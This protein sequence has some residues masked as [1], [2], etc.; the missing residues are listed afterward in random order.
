M[1]WLHKIRFGLHPYWYWPLM[2]LRAFRF[3]YAFMRALRQFLWYS[4]FSVF[5]NIYLQKKRSRKRDIRGR[6]RKF[7][8]VSTERVV[9]LHAVRSK[10][11]TLVLFLRNM[12]N[13]LLEV[14]RIKKLC[15]LL[16][17][18][19]CNLYFDQVKLINWF[20]HSNKIT[21]KLN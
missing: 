21:F 16:D 4:L 5:Q 17:I 18:R 19:K 10:Q 2:V 14:I 12:N 9:C 11:R 3:R 13:Y 15:N 20:L 7:C 6:K 1:A 8:M